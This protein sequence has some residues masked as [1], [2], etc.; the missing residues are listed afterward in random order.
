MMCDREEGR[1]TFQ[2]LQ[3]LIMFNA[4]RCTPNRSTTLLTRAVLAYRPPSSSHDVSIGVSAVKAGSVEGVNESAKYR[5]RFWISK[6]R[7][8]MLE[9]EVDMSCSILLTLYRE[10]R[11]DAQQ[12][13]ARRR[14]RE[15]T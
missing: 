11:S 13:K 1:P 4:A 5:I 6:G 12:D 10:W 3:T 14:R 7:Q 9:L 8:G 15:W 2:A